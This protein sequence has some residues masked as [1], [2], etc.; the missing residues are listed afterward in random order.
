MK[1]FK[2][3]ANMR[4]DVKLKRV[5]AK[6]GLEGYGLYNLIIESTISEVKRSSLVFNQKAILDKVVLVEA[7]ITLVF[8]KN[9]KPVRIPPMIHEKLSENVELG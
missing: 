4:H 8:V 7:Q 5:I 2:H 6:Y 3:K 1:W 9:Q